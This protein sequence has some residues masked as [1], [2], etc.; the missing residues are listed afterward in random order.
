MIMLCYGIMLCYWYW[1]IHEPPYIMACKICTTFVHY[2]WDIR[3]PPMLITKDTK[4]SVMYACLIGCYIMKKM[5]V[6]LASYI[7]DM[8]WYYG[9]PCILYVTCIEMHNHLFEKFLIIR[10]KLNHPLG[11]QGI[12]TISSVSNQI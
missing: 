3:K 10:A 2:L 9:T 8:N 11:S 6:C 1:M 4:I 7:N 12:L 5:E